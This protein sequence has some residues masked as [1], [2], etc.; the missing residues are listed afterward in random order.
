M[1]DKQTLSLPVGLLCVV[2]SVL[3]IVLAL[4]YE[5][6]TFYSVTSIPPSTAFYT[7]LTMIAIDGVLIACA[8]GLLWVAWSIIKKY[9]KAGAVT[10]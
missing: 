1:N 8:V 3:L 6:T 5:Q 4:W 2:V 7:M 9:R 10:A